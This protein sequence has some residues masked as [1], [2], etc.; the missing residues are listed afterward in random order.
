LDPYRSLWKL[1]RD[2]EKNMNLWKKEQVIFKLNADD[3]DKEAKFMLQ[4]AN[5]LHARF[6]GQNKPIADLTKSL[7]NDLNAFKNNMP[8]VKIFCNPG[9]KERHWSEIS[10]VISYVIDPNKEINLNTLI[11]LE[12]T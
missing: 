8:L 12:T 6:E 7:V 9:L 10:S 5:K 2:F 4:T 11:S 3:I 1:V